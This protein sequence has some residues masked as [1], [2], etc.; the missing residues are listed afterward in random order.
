M[1]LSCSCKEEIQPIQPKKWKKFSCLVILNGCISSNV[2]FPQF[3]DNEDL[4]SE[5]REAKRRN[6]IKVA[7]F[8]KEKTG[9]VVSPDAMF[10]IQVILFN[11]L[12]SS[13]ASQNQC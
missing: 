2:I 5:W 3:A 12:L 7:S 1:Y 6:K 10:D 9:Y 4:Q 8:I 13:N 11:E